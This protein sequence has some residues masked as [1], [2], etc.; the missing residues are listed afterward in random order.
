MKLI[1]NRRKDRTPSKAFT[2][3]EIMLSL[4]IIV[5]IAFLGKK[6]IFI[7]VDSK[8]S[9]GETKIVCKGLNVTLTHISDD[10]KSIVLLDKRQPIFEICKHGDKNEIKLLFFTTNNEQHVT[11][12]V[13]YKIVELELGKIELSR[14]ALDNAA[15]LSLQKSLTQNSSMEKFFEEIDAKNKHT[16]KFDVP[17]SEFKIRMAIKT[18][19][20]STIF[21]PLN[22]KMMYSNGILSYHKN[23][24]NISVRGDL[25]FFD[26]TLKALG[27]NDFAKLHTLVEKDIEKA[28]N[29][30][31]S[32]ARSSFVRIVPNAVS[33]Q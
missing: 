2:L 32:Y 25:S 1:V 30:L 20:G 22:T 16:H 31:F 17:L 6:L 14:I 23:G 5:A 21:T 10:L 15:T 13:Q 11:V 12:A 8:R 3:L 19:N 26:V 29:F 7:L 9:V 4:F 33:F 28:K 18:H 24:K 27:K